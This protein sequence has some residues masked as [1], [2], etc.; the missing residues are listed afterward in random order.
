MRL[1]LPLSAALVLASAACS[2]PAT[3]PTPPPGTAGTGTAGTGGTTAGTGGS[4]GTAG[5]VSA[6]TG[7]GG[8]SAGGTGGGGTGG[9]GAGGTGGTAVDNPMPTL[10]SQTG[11][12][13]DITAAEKKLGAG[14][15]AYNV[16]YALWSDN[17]EKHRWVYMPPGAKIQTDAFAGALGMAFWQFPKGFKLWKEFR[18]EGKL[19]ETRLLQKKGDGIGAW[20]MVS[21]KWNDAGT[22]AT[23][24]PDGEA[25][26]MNTMHD[27][28]AVKACEDCHSTMYDNA[29]GFS[30]LQL[31]HDDPNAGAMT[32]AKAA[33]L[34]WF[35]VPPAAEG[36]KLPGTK[37]ESDALGYL[38]ANCGMCHNQFSKVFQAKSSMDLWTRLDQIGTVEGTAAYL[39]MV[40]DQWPDKTAYPT[41]P[42]LATCGAGHAVGANMDIKD[43]SKMKRIVPKD[44]P[45]SSVHDLMSLRIAGMADPI[46]MPPLGTEIA[47]PTG[48]KTVEDWINSLTAK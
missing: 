10:L 36:Y 29:L 32:L 1:H 16:S 28:P 23:A 3:P 7:G 41:A 47:D 26:A 38:H 34:G 45:N 27:I 12:Y 18:S 30:A 13:E 37:A 11:L 21:F 5:D 9:G 24:I 44:V 20:Y 25:N 43:I 4:A 40:C 8:A 22:E 6:G 39:S 15:Y 33:E 14:V 46:Q 35:T 31:S 19:I 17:A 2:D 42:P 48:L